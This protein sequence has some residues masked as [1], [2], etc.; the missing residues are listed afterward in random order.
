LLA[1]VR[2]WRR[3]V[4]IHPGFTEPHAALIRAGRDVT[5]VHTDDDFRLR[6]ERV[7]ADADLV[8]IGNPTNPTGVLHPAEDLLALRRPGRLVVVDEAFMDAVPGETNSLSRPDVS[9]TSAVQNPDFGGIVIVRSLTKHWSIPGI[10]AGYV[11]ADPD[12]ITALADLQTPWSVST[13]ALAA[14]VALADAT[15][16]ADRRA[17]E[18]TEWTAQLT[19]EL[20]ARGIRTTDSRAPYVLAH[21]GEGMHAALREQGIAV[22]RADTFPGLDHTWVR[23]AARPPEQTTHLLTALDHL[24]KESS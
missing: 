10:R 5:M 9:L 19:T 13:P 15:D 20:R 22:R 3:P 6:P 21:L 23:I 1:R 14:M 7:P 11:L 8:V 16:D 24:T 12:T 17:T 4:V 2:P 18:L